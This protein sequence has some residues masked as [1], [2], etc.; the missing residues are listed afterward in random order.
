[1]KPLWIIFMQISLLCE[2]Y[3]RLEMVQQAL[4]ENRYE[5]D[6]AS[7]SSSLLEGTPQRGAVHATQLGL[8]DLRR[9]GEV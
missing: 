5:V 2:I 6:S 7:W 9:R 8:H 3:Q 4:A 1:M